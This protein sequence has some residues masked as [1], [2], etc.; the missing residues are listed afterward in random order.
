MSTTFSPASTVPQPVDLW[1]TYWRARCEPKR[2]LMQRSLLTSQ[3]AAQRT[4]ATTKDLSQKDTQKALQYQLDR[5]ATPAARAVHQQGHQ[6]QS[7]EKELVRRQ[8]SAREW[9]TPWLVGLRSG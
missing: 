6:A 7:Y 2:K 9:I 4:E 5:C 1:A 8:R 3:P